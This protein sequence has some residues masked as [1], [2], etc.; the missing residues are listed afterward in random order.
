MSKLS[1]CHAAR[2]KKSAACLEHFP[3]YIYVLNAH[4]QNLVPETKTTPNTCV[5]RAKLLTQIRPSFP[6]SHSGTTAPPFPIR[7]LILP[8][9]SGTFYGGSYAKQP[10]RPVL[11]PN[12]KPDRVL[13]VTDNVMKKVTGLDSV[14]SVAAVIELDLPGRARF[15][16]WVMV[17]W[18]GSQS[19]PV[20]GTVFGR[21][22]QSHIVRGALACSL[23]V[24][25]LNAIA[26]KCDHAR[27]LRRPNFRDP[28]GRCPTC[29]VGF[30]GSKVGLGLWIKVSSECLQ[31]L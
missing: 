28:W 25:P 17:G 19:V 12:L 14:A 20:L 18:F 29:C 16:D 23:C 4:M 9:A 15:E 24:Q 10:S 26:N 2:R 13:T 7:T 3:L 11:P 21:K 8:E 5:S 22:G 31:G 27:T 6:H 1:E 30:I